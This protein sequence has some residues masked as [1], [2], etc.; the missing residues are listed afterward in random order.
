MQRL[1]TVVRH[2]GSA[3]KKSQM[4]H[5]Q[6][7]CLT[8][9]VANV[10]PSIVVEPRVALYDEEVIILLQNFPPQTKVTL[11]G[12]VV[13]LYNKIVFAS[14]GHYLSDST[15]QINVATDTSEGGTYAGVEPMGI[16]W[17]LQ[18]APGHPA[19]TRIGINV[20]HQPIVVTL[21]AYLGHLHLDQIYSSDG[22]EGG[23]GGGDGPTAPQPVAQMNLERLCKARGVV[24]HEV[25]E[26][27]I[28]GALYLPPGNGP[29]QGIIDMFGSSGGLT[30]YRAALLASRGFA[31]LSLAYFKYKD[32]Q[33]HLYDLKYEYF[34]EAIKWLTSHPKVVGNG[35]G[36]LA[37]S[38]GSENA[39]L[40]G[41]YSSKVTAVVTING[42]CYATV[43]NFLRDNHVIHTAQDI[44]LDKAV[45]TEE[46][47]DV[48]GIV[49]EPTN[50]FPVWQGKAK[51]LCLESLD[52]YQTKPDSHK[53]L[54]TA[55]PKWKQKD[56]QVVQ[57]KGAG[58]LLEPPYNP[59]CRSSLNKGIGLKM[60]W[61]GQPRE[62]AHA[63]VDAWRRTLS[64][65]RDNIPAS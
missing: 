29:F 62:H 26:G 53:D 19:D 41:S 47:F 42:Y 18:A 12:Q 44:D 58:H 21:K 50:I 20:A 60:K 28:R 15:G 46:G 11:H 56:I 10:G 6:P 48:R 57:Y 36:V 17:S 37:N 45:V 65:F 14:C 40:M 43:G 34:D 16:L 52:D 5:I 55:C 2:L 54:L 13:Q 3:I 33:D 27:N 4:P 59:L 31:S 23:V 51:Y 9:T 35:V 61:G 32:L 63:Q 24:R 38:K 49:A 30:E 64:F 8:S 39:F 25:D 1:Q 22:E 7:S